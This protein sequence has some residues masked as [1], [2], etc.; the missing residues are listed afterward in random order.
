MCF[1]LFFPQSCHFEEREIAQETPYRMLPIFVDKL[2]RF[3]VP[4]NKKQGV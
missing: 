4:R 2:M 3:L 1:V